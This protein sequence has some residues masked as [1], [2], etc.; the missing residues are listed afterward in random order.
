MCIKKMLSRFKLLHG[1]WHGYR[2]LT[3]V[4]YLSV[5]VVKSRVNDERPNGWAESQVVTN[6]SW[7]FSVCWRDE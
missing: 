2:V 3:I 7:R 5:N 1:G 6:S 4:N